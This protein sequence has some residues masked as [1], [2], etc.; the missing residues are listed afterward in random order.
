MFDSATVRLQRSG[1]SIAWECILDFSTCFPEKKCEIWTGYIAK[2]QSWHNSGVSITMNAWTTEIEDY[3][4]LQKRRESFIASA[5]EARWLNI[6]Q[7]QDRNFVFL[8]CLKNLAFF[9]LQQE[10]LSLMRSTSGL[11]PEDTS[12]HGHICTILS[13]T[14]KACSQTS[15]CLW[16]S[17]STL[18]HNVSEPSRTTG[19]KPNMRYTKNRFAQDKCRNTTKRNSLD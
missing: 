3:G 10:N 4:I 8:R 5:N 17:H 14:T 11:I 1:A 2:A 16:M 19:A 12:Y 6:L 15:G 9:L 18:K 13:K 7:K